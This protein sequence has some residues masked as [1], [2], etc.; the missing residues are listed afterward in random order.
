MAYGVL[1]VAVFIGSLCIGETREGMFP[2]IPVCLLI[3]C[4]SDL[5]SGNHYA[6]LFDTQGLT[7][8]SV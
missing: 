4:V 6:S 2:I 3:E 7:G 5:A 8:G 1:V